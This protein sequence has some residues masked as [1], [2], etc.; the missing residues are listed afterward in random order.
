MLN[1][2]INT[3]D[4]AAR[5]TR[6]D[7]V[8]KLA[9]EWLGA[10]V[11]SVG[12]TQGLYIH[13]L[14]AHVAD[15]VRELGDLRPYQSQ[16]L[17]HCHSVRKLIA[18]MLTNRQKLGAHSRTEQTLRFLLTAAQVRRDQRNDQDAQ[19]WAQKEETARLRKVKRVFEVNHV[20][21]KTS[22]KL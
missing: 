11:T 4:A 2:A 17:E 12:N 5:G 6:A 14:H 19:E 3:Q 13:L 7:T 18:K 20:E 16:G 8:Q 10:W 9:D 22:V 1:N 21:G 15:W